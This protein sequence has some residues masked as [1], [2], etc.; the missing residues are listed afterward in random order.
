MSC[1]RCAEG[2]RKYEITGETMEHHGRI[3]MRIRRLSDGAIGGWIQAEDNLSHHGDCWVANEA[4][5]FDYCKIL[6]NAQVTGNAEVMHSTM[7]YGDSKMSGNA[8]ALDDARVCGQAAVA[9]TVCDEAIVAGTT[10]VF[11][12]VTVDGRT[13]LFDGDIK[14]QPFRIIE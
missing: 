14:P 13:V 3:L 2:I 9:G 4:K 5:A 6:D 1:E 7:V 12:G 10:R 8:K 11:E